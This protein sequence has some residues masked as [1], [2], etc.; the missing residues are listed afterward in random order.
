MNTEVSTPAAGTLPLPVCTP[1]S[2][3]DLV[4]FAPASASQLA[5]AVMKRSGQPLIACYQCRRCAAGCPVNQETDG[6]TPNVL[7]RMIILGD[8]HNAYANKLLWKC[9]SCNTCG[10]RCPNN[11]N[12]GRIVESMKKMTKEAGITPLRPEVAHFHTSC[13]NDSLRWGRISEMGMMGEYEIRN[14]VQNIKQ[15]K[16]RAIIDEISYQLKFAY[17]MLKLGRLHLFFHTSRGRFELRKLVQ[18]SA[19]KKWI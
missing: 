17:K 9:L 5:R 7:I 16:F 6:V 3:E 8:L 12:T 1:G 18:N 4:T 11:I 10:T 14:L 2:R 19:G 15:K 13:Y